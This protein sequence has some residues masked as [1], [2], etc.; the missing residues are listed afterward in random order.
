M[1]SKVKMN[2]CL[3][4]LVCYYNKNIEDKKEY[5][6][7]FKIFDETE[8]NYDIEEM[9]SYDD[10]TKAKEAL[11]EFIT[12]CGNSINTTKISKAKEITEPN[13]SNYIDEQEQTI[14][15]VKTGGKVKLT[16]NLSEYNKNKYKEN[17]DK[18]KTYYDANK[19]KIRE[20]QKKRYQEM[21]EKLTELDKLKNRI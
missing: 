12:K 15:Q 14:K 18:F 11:M 13:K 5:K 8:D 6:P 9:G 10:R 20:Y 19:I 21:K 1:V 2:M 7:Y 17:K 4:L 16:T 3:N